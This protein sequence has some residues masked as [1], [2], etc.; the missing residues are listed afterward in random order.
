MSERIYTTMDKST[1]GDGPWQHEPDKVQW[2]DEATGLPCLAV[3][4][5]FGAWCGYVGVDEDHP[6]H[7]LG[8]DDKAPGPAP[9][10]VGR[11]A[12][13]YG[14]GGLIA[15]LG[16]KLDEFAETVAGR[17]EVHGGLTYAGFCQEGSEEEAICHVPE[18]GQSDNV[19]WFG[20]DCHHCDDI[21]PGL[22]ARERELGHEPIRAGT[23]RYRTLGYVQAEV[24]SLA[25][26][27]SEAGA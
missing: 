6:W 23:E 2:T 7:G 22:E 16:G 1:W 20:F 14:M 18:P 13:G 15:V 10:L 25:R 17:V 11:S 4:N 9:D 27:V 26:Q 24:A 3:R 21:G 8:C 19:W 5:R 12:D